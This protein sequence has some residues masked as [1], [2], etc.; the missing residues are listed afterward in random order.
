[1]TTLNKNRQ[2]P[3]PVCPDCGW[4]KLQYEHTCRKN[5]S[6][7]ATE[8]ARRVPDVRSTQ[9][10]YGGGMLTFEMD[11]HMS[12]RFNV[13]DRKGVRKPLRCE[14]VFLIGELSTDEAT[15]LVRALAD[16]RRRMLAARAS[17]DA[18]VYIDDHLDCDYEDCQRC[19][20]EDA[21]RAG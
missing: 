14:D 12:V 6:R 11:E 16:W 15:D 1:M 9:L 7:V 3:L 18:S 17:G 20:P 13:D 5:A 10:G 4:H 8:L 21:V 19:H 2:K